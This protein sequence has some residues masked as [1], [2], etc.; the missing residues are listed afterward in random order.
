MLINRLY[1]SSN[2]NT[3]ERNSLGFNFLFAITQVYAAM[4]ARDY[5]DKAAVHETMV[6]VRFEAA[7]LACYLECFN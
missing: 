2:A 5:L 7:C 6:K 3:V 1:R 4:K